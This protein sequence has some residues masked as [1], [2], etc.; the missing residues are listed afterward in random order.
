VI[1][2]AHNIVCISTI[3]WDFVWQGHQEIMS[4]LARQGHRVLFIENTGV[5][6]VKFKDLPRLRHRLAN[7]HKGV[8]G[9]RKV[10]DNLYV[11]APIVLPF[12]YSRV[13]RLVNQTVMFW[14]LKR[15]TRSM[16]FDNPIVW[17]WLPTALALKLIEALNAQIVVYYCCDDFSTASSGSRRIRSTE[18]LLIRKADL[19]F[20]HS[21]AIYDRCSR[22]TDRV[23]MFQYGFNRDVFT[24]ISSEVPDDLAAIP[25]PILGYVGGVHKHVDQ[26]LLAKVATVHPD[27]SL[28][29]I[30]PLQVDVSRL[31]RLP[32]VHCLGQKR[33]EELPSYI[34]HFGLGLI[35]YEVNEYTRSVFPTK[36]NEYLIM[37]KP[38]V[39]TR[40]P[41]IEYFNETHQSV[42]ALAGDHETF[43]RRIDEELARDAE[44]LQARRIKLVEGNTWDQRIE[45]MIGLIQA[46]LDEKAKTREINWQQTLARIY[47]TSLRKV[48]GGVAAVVLAYALLFYTPLVWWVAEPLRFA[49]P[50]QPADAIVVL[51]G[52]I[53]ESGEPGEEYQEKVE[54][55]VKLYREGYAQRIIFSSGVGHVYK[56]AQVMKAL[57]V[58]IGV[59]ESAIIL[60]KRGGGNYVSLLTAK[61]ILEINGWTRMLLV[62]SRYNTA[63]SRLVIEKNLPAFQVRFTPAPRSAFFGD[64]GP[65]VWKHVRAILHEYGAIVYYRLKGYV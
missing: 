56:E 33:Y 30:G 43:V 16:R 25:R 5:R 4:T 59:P 57:A 48:A 19:V 1:R 61:R 63:R 3:D 55:G 21:K 34:R 7:W 45:D 62:T 38:V 22:L 10:M 44:A 50:P 15:W 2:E 49:D 64:R 32:N 12:P 26:D 40:L 65:V 8:R 54:H 31:S 37:G 46:K 24:H 29:L 27:K 36:L 42:V 11:Y 23:F 14:T 60:D 39:S 35:P 6:S 51:A 52:G 28:V 41:E 9:I 58:S 13:A 20:A 18:D 53:G 47:Q 17:T